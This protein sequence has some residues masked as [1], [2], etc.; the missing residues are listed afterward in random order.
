M[1]LCRYIE[2]FLAVNVIEIHDIWRVYKPAV[3]TWTILGC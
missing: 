1:F 3:Y 2:C